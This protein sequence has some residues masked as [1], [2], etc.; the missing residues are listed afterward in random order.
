MKSMKINNP[1]ARSGIFKVKTI[2]KKG[3]SLTLNSW[4]IAS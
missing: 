2:V 4:N 1:H 3:H